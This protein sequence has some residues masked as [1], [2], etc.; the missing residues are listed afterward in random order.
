MGGST[1]SDTSA[2]SMCADFYFSD[3]GLEGCLRRAGKLS[4]GVG[5]VNVANTAGPID[6]A[7]KVEAIFGGDVAQG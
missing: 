4:A 5:F 2:E 1:N 6:V 3:L 7:R